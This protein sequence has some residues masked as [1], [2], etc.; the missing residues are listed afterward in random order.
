MLVVEEIRHYGGYGP[1]TIGCAEAIAQP[2]ICP[3]IGRNGLDAC[4]T[5]VDRCADEVHPQVGIHMIGQGC[6]NTQIEFVLRREV[7]R[8]PLLFSTS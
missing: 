8:P 6:L 7:Y 2:C 5:M 1:G 3:G 4:G